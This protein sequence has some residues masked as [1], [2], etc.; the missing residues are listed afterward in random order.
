M[1]IFRAVASGVVTIVI[2]T[3]VVAGARP[4]AAADSIDPAADFKAFR[5][6]FT[7]LFPDVPLNDFVNGPY[8]MDAELRK[9]WEAIDDFPPYDFSGWEFAF[10][11]DDKC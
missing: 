11:R 8:S 7:K 6:Y 3:L 4:A 9:Q 5:D 2:A 10:G 1:R